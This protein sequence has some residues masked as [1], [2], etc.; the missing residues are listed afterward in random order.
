MEIAGRIGIGIMDA[1]GNS[2]AFCAAEYREYSIDSRMRWRAS[3][4][5]PTT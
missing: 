3:I 5:R 1:N 4:L 2:S